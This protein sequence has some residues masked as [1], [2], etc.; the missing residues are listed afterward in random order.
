MNSYRSGSLVIEEILL[1]SDVGNTYDA[2]SVDYRVLDE[3][4]T[5]LVTST[6]ISTFVAGDVSVTITVPTMINTLPMGELKGMRAIELKLTLADT[7]V[8]YFTTY[9]VVARESTLI[10]MTNSYQ[11]LSQAKLMLLDMPD[12]LGWESATDKKRS[13]AMIESFYRL[14]L[15]KYD[16]YGLLIPSRENTVVTNRLNLDLLDTQAVSY[17]RTRPSLSTLSLEEFIGLP[18]LFTDAVKKAQ[19]SEADI[20]LGGDP[21]QK[22]RDEGLMSE[23][24][25]ES[26]SMF[27]PGVPLALPVNKRTLNYLSGWVTYRAHIGR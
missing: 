3:T 5:E 1:L 2:I 4:D 16:I 19:I 23:S 24:V 12:M 14:G 9:Y 15:L 8:F 17:Y 26:S 10:T 7:T 13:A 21:V 22:K 25:G 20:I 27:R 11:T 18:I 6:S